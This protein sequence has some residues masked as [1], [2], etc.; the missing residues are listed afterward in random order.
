MKATVCNS[1]KEFT[2]SDKGAIFHDGAIAVL[3]K[4]P[5][6]SKQHVLPITDTACLTNDKTWEVRTTNPISLSPAIRHE[7]GW[8]GHLSQGN[9][10]VV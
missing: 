9:W 6:C 5:S 8:H 1:I 4:C 2:E 7:C 10:R 3:M